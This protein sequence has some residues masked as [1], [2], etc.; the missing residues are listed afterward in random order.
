MPIHRK[1][2]YS[3]D[4]RVPTKEKYLTE[5]PQSKKDQYKQARKLHKRPKSSSNSQGP[6]KK[7]IKKPVFFSTIDQRSPTLFPSQKYISPENIICSPSESPKKASQNYEVVI[8][9]PSKTAISIKKP[10]EIP[11][12]KIFKVQSYPYKKEGISPREFYQTGN[13]QSEKYLSSYSNGG[14]NQQVSEFLML[15]KENTGSFKWTFKSKEG[16]KGKNKNIDDFERLFYQSMGNEKG[17]VVSQKA[18]DFSHFK[19]FK[20][21][22][23]SHFRSLSKHKSTKHLKNKK[24]MRVYESKSKKSKRVSPNCSK[25]KSR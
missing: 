15:N 7:V 17:K 2:V 6:T 23:P 24:S 3:N 8:Q 16:D 22:H 10:T 4:G 13:S 21:Q 11:R 14:K 18:V 20:V 5:H 25:Y 1:N 9:K 12:N 19:N